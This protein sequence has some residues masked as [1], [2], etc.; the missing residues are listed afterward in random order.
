[1]TKS[2]QKRVL[3]KFIQP[4]SPY[5]VGEVTGVRPAKAQSLIAN[6]FCEPVGESKTQTSDS[7]NKQMLAD[8]SKRKYVTK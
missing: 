2:N 4:L 1:M 7:H 6:G 8:R 3:V 5:T